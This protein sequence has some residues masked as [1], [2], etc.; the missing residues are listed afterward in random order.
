MKLYLFFIIFFLDQ[1]MDCMA[2]DLKCHIDNFTTLVNS[3]AISY[4]IVLLYSYVN[5]ITRGK[6]YED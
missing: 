5:L 6:C 1:I 2:E 4:R 3:C